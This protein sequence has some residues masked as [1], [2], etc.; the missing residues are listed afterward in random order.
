VRSPLAYRR[1]NGPLADVGALAASAYFGSFALVA[2]TFSNPIVLCGAAAG[3]VVAGRMAGAGRALGLAARYGLALG[4]VFVAVNALAAHRGE[5]I[6]VRLGEL[7]VLGRVDVSAEALCEGAILA[8]RVLVVMMAFAV[9]SATVDPDRL[10]RLLR[11]VARRSALTATLV[12]R[13]V[14]LAAR[15]YGRLSEAT[16]LRGPAAAPVG[17]A[18]MVRR[19]V[20]GSLDRAVDIA[21]TLELRGYARGA[22]R[23]ADGRTAGRH[24]AAFAAAGLAIIGSA[25]AAAVAG[26]GGFEAYPGIAMETDRATIALA[27][28]VPLLAWAPFALA[29]VRRPSWRARPEAAGA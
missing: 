19:L 12:T 16:S 21:A 5:T 25:T 13:L 14:P 24:S 7:P 18:A 1:P 22:P 15:D 26:V 11:P 27:V 10:L 20:A 6:L 3:V 28:L 2:F 9:L 17:R 8:G 4:A 23:R 29:M